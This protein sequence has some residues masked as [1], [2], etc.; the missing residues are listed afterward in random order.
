[1]ATGGRGL[2]QWQHMMLGILSGV[3]VTLAVLLVVAR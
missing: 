2:W 1:M 3:A